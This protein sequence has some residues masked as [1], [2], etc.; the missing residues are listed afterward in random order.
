MTAVKNAQTNFKIHIKKPHLCGFLF[1]IIVTNKP[2]HSTYLCT[3]SGNPRRSLGSGCPFC[4][5]FFCRLFCAKCYAFAYSTSSFIR[6]LSVRSAS[7]SHR[8]IKSFSI[9]V[10]LSFFDI[11]AFR[12]LR[13]VLCTNESSLI[14]IFPG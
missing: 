9:S 10:G 14:S 12:L 13:A 1:V 11:I 2:S 3:P 6:L 7:M 4:T 8:S 5:I